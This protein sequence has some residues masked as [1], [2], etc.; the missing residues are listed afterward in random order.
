MLSDF[1]AI[2]YVS[3]QKVNLIEYWQYELCSLMWFLMCDLF[4]GSLLFLS[5]YDVELLDD[6]QMNFRGCGRKLSWHNLKH[7]LSICV[8]Q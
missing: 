1:C 3:N 2:L 4:N 5:L 7:C 8:L 6:R